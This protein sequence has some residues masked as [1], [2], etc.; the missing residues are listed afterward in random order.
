MRNVLNSSIKFEDLC[1][2]PFRERRFFYAF[3]E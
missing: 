3:Y 1:A 2:A